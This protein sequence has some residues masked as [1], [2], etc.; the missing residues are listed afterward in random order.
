[1][2][3]AYGMVLYPFVLFKPRGPSNMLYKHEFI[4]C[5]QVKDQGVFKFYT[6]YIWNYIT[7]GYENHP[8]EIE[9]FSQ[10]HEPLTE[11]EKEWIRTGEV[12]IK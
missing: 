8:M 7:K 10:H 3:W 4:H 6:S 1:M 2:F 11:A 9:A 5:Y 12:H